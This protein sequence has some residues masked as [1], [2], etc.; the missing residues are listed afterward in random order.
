MSFGLASVQDV[1]GRFKQIGD[2]IVEREGNF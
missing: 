2:E 1:W